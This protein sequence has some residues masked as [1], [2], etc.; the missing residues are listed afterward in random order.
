V[1][2]PDLRQSESADGVDRVVGVGVVIGVVAAIAAGAAIWLLLTDPVSIATA[3]ETGEI[4]PL[5]RQL[6]DVL[7]SAL[8]G[9]LAY[10]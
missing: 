8:T 1:P 7:W 5:A 4:S 2:S 3:V 10:L 9:L 6:A